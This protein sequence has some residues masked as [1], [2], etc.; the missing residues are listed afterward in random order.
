MCVSGYNRSE[1]SKKIFC[2]LGK[3]EMLGWAALFLH[4]LVV[5]E[6]PVRSGFLTP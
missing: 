6:S 1:P 3:T 4:L 5:F 2:A